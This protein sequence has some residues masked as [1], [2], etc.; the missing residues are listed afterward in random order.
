MIV[1]PDGIS[2]ILCHLRPSHGNLPSQKYLSVS[3]VPD[4]N[5]AFSN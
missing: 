1:V 5:S 2:P 3:P 4:S